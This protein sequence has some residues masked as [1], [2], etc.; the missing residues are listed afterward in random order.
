[1]VARPE[2]GRGGA[3]RL[4]RL[5][6]NASPQR[7][8]PAANPKLDAP[9]WARG[10]ARGWRRAKG[11]D[12]GGPWPGPGSRDQRNSAL[13]GRLTSDRNPT[14][15]VTSGHETVR[16][17]RQITKSIQLVLFSNVF[18]GAPN[19]FEGGFQHPLEW[20]PTIHVPLPLP[21]N[22]RGNGS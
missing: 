12:K 4:G 21:S 11:G 17:Y 15:I 20:L 3:G 1:M 5:E 2:N 22:F 13:R 19:I 9:G 7:L 6:R 8:Q 16:V 18:C 14:Q 10:L